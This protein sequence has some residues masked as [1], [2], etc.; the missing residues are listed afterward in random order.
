MPSPAILAECVIGRIDRL[1][2]AA[3]IQIDAAISVLF[4]RI[5]IAGD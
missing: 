2:V 3:H 5:R 1:K 4:V